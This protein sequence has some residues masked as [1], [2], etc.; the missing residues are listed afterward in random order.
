MGKRSSI[1]IKN[2]FSMRIHKKNLIY[3]VIMVVLGLLM[4]QII[5]VRNLNIYSILYLSVENMDTGALIIGAFKLVILNCIRALPNYLAAFLIAESVEIKAFGEKI[6][7]LRGFLGIIIVPVIYALIFLL[8]DIKYD[9]GIPAIIVIFFIV[10]LEKLNF[11]TISI[12]KKSLIMILLLLGVQWMDI[13]PALSKFGFGRGEISGDVKMISEFIDGSEALSFAACTFC[14]IFLMN[15]FLMF[16]I[17]KDQHNLIVITKENRIVEKELAKTR[18]QALEART[19]Q[20]IQSLV[21][22]LKTPLTSI[23]ALTSVIELTTHDEKTKAYM[24]RVISSVD[25]LSSMIS[26]ILYEDKKN[27]VGTE[28]FFR[29]ILSQISTYTY[30]DRIQIHNL[31]PEK[32]LLANKIR[33][34]R[35]IINAINNS[36]D[37]IK[38]EGHVLIT[39]DSKVG[40]IMI[41]IEDDGIGIS[42]EVRDRIWERG[43]STK[44][45]TGIGLKFVK[46]VIDNHNGMID[47]V[48]EVN[49]GTKL[50]ICLPE[51]I[52]DE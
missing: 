52:K 1:E 50:I 12:F 9:F 30:M 29:L 11:S 35:A 24:C 21:H 16:K 19:Y 34:S 40:Y 20:E 17:L 18:L 22:D 27:V 45:S 47:L 42:K 13:I 6:N 32:T 15:A 8:H 37:A 51:V 7:W 31:C 10:Y 46:K 5:N 4:P 38:K 28:E 25:K 41:T 2:N 26:E 33:L 43:F 23:Q 49:K 36:L 48:S 14:G 44:G 3:G 39:V